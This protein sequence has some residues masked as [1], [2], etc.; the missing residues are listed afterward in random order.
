[1]CEMVIGGRDVGHAVVEH[2]FHAETISTSSEQPASIC[3]P[4]EMSGSG[5]KARSTAR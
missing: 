5:T 4:S 2:G 1:L 3:P